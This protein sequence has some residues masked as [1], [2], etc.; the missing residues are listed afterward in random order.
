MIACPVPNV[1][2]QER[3]GIKTVKRKIPRRST[4]CYLNMYLK[5]LYRIS[6]LLET[7]TFMLEFY[8]HFCVLV[9]QT[10]KE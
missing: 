6:P 1:R 5:T 8:T 3:K 4:P 2:I 10:G 9:L 7:M